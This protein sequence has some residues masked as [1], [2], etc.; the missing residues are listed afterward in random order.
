[1]RRLDP[2]AAPVLAALRQLHEDKASASLA[3][4][5]QQLGLPPGTVMRTVSA[6]IDAQ[7]VQL[8]RLRDQN[9]GAELT[10]SGLEFVRR[11]QGAVD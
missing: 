8:R 11:S 2:A 4:L 9:I 10:K 3:A 5:S 6:L 7:L 1:M